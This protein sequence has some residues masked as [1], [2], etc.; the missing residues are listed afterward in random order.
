MNTQLKMFIALLIVSGCV[1]TM[2]GCSSLYVKTEEYTIR[3]IDFFKSRSIDE[4]N[5]R[6]DQN[7][8]LIIKIEKHK[9]TGDKE[10]LTALGELV[11]AA[12]RAAATGV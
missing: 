2:I 10:S 11:G 4:G 5:I 6:R 1:L 9:E 8:N 12:A 7:G 3:Q